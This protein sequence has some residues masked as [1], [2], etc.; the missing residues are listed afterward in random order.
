MEAAGIEPASAVAPVRASTSLACALLSPGGRFAGDLPPGQPSLVS[1]PSGDWLSF[2]AS[3]LYDAATRIT[4]R[5][6]SDASP[7]YL[8][9]ECEFVYP[10][11][12]C[13]PVVLRGLPG[14]SACSS[15]GEPTTSKPGRPRMFVSHIVAAPAQPALRPCAGDQDDE[16]SRSAIYNATVCAL[17]TR[18]AWTRCALS[19][20]R[21]TTSTG[22]PSSCR[23]R[24]SVSVTI[25]RPWH[26]DVARLD[27]AVLPAQRG[28]GVG[29]ALC[30]EAS[31]WPEDHG[32][33]SWTERF[34]KR[35]Q[36]PGL[37][38]QRGFWEHVAAS[39][40]SSS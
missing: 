18:S 16:G 33:D 28:R 34:P 25:E 6:R 2:G 13:F 1:H 22:P 36:R 5:I 19:G 7:N 32:V 9:G 11:L 3:P 27:F 15:A 4:G 40:S 38:V 8:G 39:G 10:H 24:P 17:A 26:P 20:R 30:R 14:T 21:S 37:R 29:S 31:A 12:H 23:R 35:T